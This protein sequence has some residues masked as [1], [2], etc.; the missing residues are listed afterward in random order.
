MNTQMTKIS[1]IVLSITLI[2]AGAAGAAVLH[3]QSAYDFSGPGFFNVIAGAPPMGVTTYSVNDIVVDGT[4]WNITSISNYVNALG[5]FDSEVTTAV[6][7][8]FPKTD[9]LPVEIP[10]NDMVVPVTVTSIGG[11]DYMV[12]ADGLNIELEPGEYW[13][14][15]TH[16]GSA[17]NSGIHMPA[18][19][20]MGDATPSYDTGGF[21]M[22][23][24]M[25]WVADTDAAILIPGD[26]S[27][28]GTDETSLDTVKSYYR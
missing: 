21:P 22:P 7:N 4:G 17:F 8:I 24:W 19:T 3:D 23:M 27:I 6:I 13:I 2:V 10:N 5:G 26:E 18:V 25:F 1:L 14:G 20:L 9:S 12:T 15:L 11:D 16:Y 28:V